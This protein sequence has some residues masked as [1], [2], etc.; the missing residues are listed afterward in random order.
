M[1]RL[2][3]Y[4][5]L[6]TM[7]CLMA[8]TGMKHIEA[9]DPL[10]TGHTIKYR[11]N[12]TDK[13]KLD[14]VLQ[15]VFKPHPNKKFLWMRPAL[16]RYN[17]ISDSARTKRFWK[18]R[19][20]PP[21]LL[22]EVQ[23]KVIT[24][25]MRDRLFQLG[26]FQNEV[27]FDTLYHGTRKAKFE[28]IITHKQ[29]YTIGSVSYPSPVNDLTNQIADARDKSLLVPGEEYTLDA[30]KNERTRI[31]NALKEAGYIYF[32]P[33][34][35][36]MRADSAS[37]DHSVR[38]AVSVKPET[39]PESKTAFTIRKVYV[40]DDNILQSAEQDTFAFG[41]YYLITRQNAIEFSTLQQGI[42]LKPGELYARSN[43]MHTVRYLS[44]LP[45]IRNVNIKF[46]PIDNTDQLDVII[47]LSQQKRFAYTAEF[48]TV[49]RSTNYFGPGAIFSYTDRN[50]NRGAELLKLNVRGSIEMQI[51]DGHVNPA[52][53][54]GIGVNY[55]LPRFF[56]GFLLSSDLK[57][58]PKTTISVGYNLF[59]RL[60]LYRLNSVVANL[61]YSWS[62]TDR[63][64]HS[65][66]PIEVTYTRLP[67][68]SKSDEFNDYLEENPGVQRSFDEQFILGM[69]YEFVYQ[70]SPNTSNGLFFR[71]GVDVA[72]YV[73]N[74][75]YSIADGPKDSLGRY[76]MFGVPFSQ[77][78]RPR[79]DIRYGLKLGAH[80]NLVSRFS[81]G[82][83]IPA[84]NSDILPYVKQF[85]VGGTNSLR[86]FIA[87]SVGPGSEVPPSGYNDVT[88]DIR[89]EGNLEYRF[90]LAGILHGALFVDAGNIWL[91]NEDP[92]RP[93]GNF[94]FD[95]FLNE[96]AVSAGW[97]LRWD[98]DFL[99]ARL[100]FGYT[101]RTPYLPEG[102]RWTTD[103]SFWNPAV[104]IAI[105]YPF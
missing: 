37:G 22:S 3:L 58:L 35:I 4:I 63:M 50:A 53:E 12:T 76:T 26:Y 49:F 84:G 98:F 33:E 73:L 74:L 91:Y 96:I 31:D 88:G 25:A 94:T 105:G 10:F 5:M 57:S 92:S 97:G 52:Y 21:V 36:T 9:T 87:R 89:L 65:F 103:L 6:C 59:N 20:A 38:I 80:S 51:V 42:F 77:Y 95:T 86:S 82:V 62:K 41:D 32:S 66:H 13:K 93:N 60:D 70:S 100:D 14:P 29:P 48:N 101:V 17:M 102:E 72:G 7:G 23:P 27:Q 104:N 15:S 78:I 64:V 11:D 24:S 61:K 79:V 55:T 83:G 68:E 19:I 44:D 40:H 39:P 90:Q 1:N 30:V 2:L 28:Y 81:A 56:P 46:L 99:V 43:Y 85:Y 8:C 18:K 71:G 34:F 75:L 47:F 54:L 45:I 69:G 67:E 16:A